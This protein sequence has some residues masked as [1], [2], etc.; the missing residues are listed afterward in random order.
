MY[1]FLSELYK[2]FNCTSVLTVAPDQTQCKGRTYMTP[3]P[4]PPPQAPFFYLVKNAENE[5]FIPA[6]YPGNGTLLKYS[7]RISFWN[8]LL[9]TKEQ[10]PNRT[11]LNDLYLPI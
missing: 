10:G 8:V 6:P 2:P 4:F 5:I 1:L 9:T 3:P 11:N 7:K